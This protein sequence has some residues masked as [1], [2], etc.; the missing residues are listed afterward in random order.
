MI[1]EERKEIRKKE[2][3]MKENKREK[4]YKGRE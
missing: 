3:N 1:E 4:Q 2:R